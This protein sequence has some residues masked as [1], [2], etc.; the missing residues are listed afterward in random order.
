MLF[1]AGEGD[2]S[3]LCNGI[4]EYQIEGSEDKGGGFRWHFW[5]HL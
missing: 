3:L 2:C 1:M 4:S 5:E